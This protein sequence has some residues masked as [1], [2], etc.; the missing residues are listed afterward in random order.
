MSYAEN[1][2]VAPEKS[3]AEIKILMRKYGAVDFV[4]GYVGG[5]VV[6]VF[7]AKERRVKFRVVMPQPNEKRFTHHKDGRSQFSDKQKADRYEQEIRRLW[8]ALLLSIKAKL[9]TVESGI[10]TF[11][12][13]FMANI[14]MP[15]GRTVGEHVTPQIAES[16]ASGR[17]MPLMLSAGGDQ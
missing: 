11:E 5:E 10:E 9:E 16:Y 12:H 3:E 15:D 8:R 14:V 13:A 7:T 17:R 1:T 2:T 6:I 4:S